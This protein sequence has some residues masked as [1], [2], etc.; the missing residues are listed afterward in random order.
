LTLRLTAL[1]SEQFIIGQTV[2]SYVVALSIT[3]L[4]TTATPPVSVSSAVEN[5]TI[6]AWEAGGKE[7]QYPP[8]GAQSSAQFTAQKPSLQQMPATDYLE[9]TLLAGENPLPFGVSNVNIK[10]SNEQ[11]KTVIVNNN[12]FDIDVKFW[13]YLNFGGQ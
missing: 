4:F 9:S 1:T 3:A 11:V 5:I 7:Q 2:E 10:E 6:G 8:W 13:V 12:S